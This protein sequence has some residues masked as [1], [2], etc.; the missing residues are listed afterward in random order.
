M[1]AG[2]PSET[3]VSNYHTTQH[4]NSEDYILFLHLCENLICHKLIVAQLVKKF[5]AFY[6]TERSITMFTGV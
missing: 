1:E 2:Q 4:N 3:V 5:L 6:R